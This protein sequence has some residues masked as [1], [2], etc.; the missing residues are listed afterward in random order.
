[1][2]KEIYIR[3]KED[4]NY[5]EGVLE[6]SN[7]IE[8]L[9]GKLRL[10]FNTPQG[11]MLGDI[12]FGLSLETELFTFDINDEELKAKIQ[13]QIEMYIDETKK[14]KIDLDIQRFKGTVRDIVLID[15]FV[16]ATKYIGFLIK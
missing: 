7:E 1:M 11:S 15:V 13:S 14:Y 4:P 10:I 2:I 5:V 6:H 3:D 12:D 16:D 8:M 9:L